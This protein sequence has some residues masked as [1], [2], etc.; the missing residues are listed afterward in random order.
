MLPSEGVFYGAYL[1]TQY[2][3]HQDSQDQLF[4]GDAPRNQDRFLVRRARASVGAEWEYA[5]LAMELDANTT[6]GH[7]STFARQRLLFSIGPIDPCL[8]Y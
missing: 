5:A 6:S 4:Q 7:K 2:E 3:S 8:P 1:Q